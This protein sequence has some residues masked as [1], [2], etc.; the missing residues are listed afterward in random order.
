MRTFCTFTFQRLGVAR[1]E[2][3]RL[4]PKLGVFPHTAQ[5]LD[6]FYSHPFTEEP[7]S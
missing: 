6:I 4:L 5:I 1:M 7:G 2:W 3:L